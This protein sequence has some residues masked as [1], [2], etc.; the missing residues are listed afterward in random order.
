M[1]VSPNHPNPPR[2]QDVPQESGQRLATFP[3]PRNG[4]ELRVTLEEYNG[5]PFLSLRVWA[6]GTGGQLWPV[7][8]KGLSIR[9]REV[10]E[11]AEVLARVAEDLANGSLVAPARHHSETR[12]HPG[13]APASPSPAAH[14]RP[15]AGRPAEM[16][17][18]PP[19]EPFDEFADGGH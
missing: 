8:G 19:A 16:P 11:L 9:I 2:S 6:P 18:R 10:A 13:H 5:H 4:E 7:R 12:H 15:A 1:W 17:R 3:R 14:H